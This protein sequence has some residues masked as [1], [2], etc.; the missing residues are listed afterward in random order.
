MSPRQNTICALIGAA[1]FVAALSLDN[2]RPSWLVIQWPSG[3]VERICSSSKESCQA[4]F[5]A[6][7]DGR[8]LPGA[9]PKGCEVAE[10]SCFP[11]GSDCIKGFNCPL[12]P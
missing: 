8:W 1:A 5:K 9:I 6:I 3:R 4:A 10:P 2:Y 11:P 12:K 7:A